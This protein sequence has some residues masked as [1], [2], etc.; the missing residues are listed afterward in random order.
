VGAR[1]KWTSPW[2]NHHGFS[3]PV[4]DDSSD[5]AQSP[6]ETESELYDDS[7]SA[8]INCGNGSKPLFG[9]GLRNTPPNPRSVWKK[10]LFQP[11]VPMS[12][13]F[14]RRRFLEKALHRLY[15]ASPMLLSPVRNARTTAC[16]TLC[17]SMRSLGVCIS[18]VSVGVV[19][20]RPSCEWRLRSSSKLCRL[21]STDYRFGDNS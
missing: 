3:V 21:Q 4:A 7:G 16:T 6:Q 13:R 11:S 19:R 20:R 10:S 12:I 14:L 5:L 18:P 1:A 9:F 8:H 17:R 15:F 2:G